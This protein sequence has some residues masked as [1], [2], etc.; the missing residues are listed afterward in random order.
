MKTAFIDYQDGEVNLQ[1]FYAHNDTIDKKKP[2]VLIAHDWSGQS[3][4]TEEKAKFFANL[5]YI[6]FAIDVYG[7]GIKG[8]TKEEKANLIKPFIQ[9][10]TKLKKRLFAAFDQ[11]KKLPYADADAIGAVGFC[12]GGLCVLDLARSGA[13]LKCAISVHGILN[14]PVPAE[15][16]PVKA[17]ILALHGYDDPMVKPEEVISFAEEMT[18]RQATWEIDI[19]GLTKHA[20]TNPLANDP[21]FGTVFNEL[22]NA[23]AMQA[24]ELYLA[25]CF[26]E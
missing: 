18:Q 12:F 10:R 22:S 11:A 1:G 8:V 5:G 23:R 7:K 4:F 24:I 16:S 15:K 6:G 20:F 13:K 26:D 25:D 3:K 2:V 17:K 9:D 19:Y 21:D 14:A